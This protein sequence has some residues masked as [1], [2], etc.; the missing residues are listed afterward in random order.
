[1]K[2][3]GHHTDDR[4]RN[5]IQQNA[6][7]ECVWVAFKMRLPE[8]IAQNR[9]IGA[10]RAVFIGTEIAAQKRF[11]A[12]HVK[13]FRRDAQSLQAFGRSCSRQVETY[14]CEGGKVLERA[15]VLL[16]EIKGERIKACVAFE[17]ASKGARN[18][19]HA[20]GV[21]IRQRVEE[22]SVNNA[23]HRRVGPDA[24][25]ERQYSHGREA[26]VLRQHAQAVTDVLHQ[27]P[28]D[29]SSGGGRAP[30]CRSLDCR[31]VV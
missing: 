28:H 23:K 12:I 26:G 13:V 27:C 8:V 18:L 30:R 25:R 5:S 17:L 21:R 14:A 31:P 16:P 20:L 2:S 6:S 10:S 9:D 24:K 19:D 22:H 7:A 4:V 1:L 29:A 3:G 15:S 11:D